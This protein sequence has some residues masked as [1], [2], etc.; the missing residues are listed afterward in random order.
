MSSMLSVEAPECTQCGDCA[1]ACPMGLITVDDDVPQTAPEAP[2]RCMLCGHCVAACPTSA[3]SH[4][5][6]RPE[7]CASI[8]PGLSLN[9][10]QADQFLRGRRSIRVYRTD[11][12]DR[13]A[14]ARLIGTASTGPSGHNTQPVEWLVIHDTAEVR[15][16]TGFVIDW[17]RYM[18][19]QQPDFAK[20]I[21]L[22][23]VVETWEKGHDAVCRNAP[24]V[25]LTYAHKDNGMAPSACTIALAY[26]ELAAQAN[27]L[28]ACW[29]GY[30]D[31]A[32]R[33]WSPLQKE[34]GLPAD[35]VSYG[36]MMIG[37]PKFKYHRIPLRKDARIS[38]K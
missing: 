10:D 28:G 1:T 8:K 35:N 19:E 15:R 16:L 25:V 38:W 3:L 37:Y 2:S 9:A 5:A 34:L 27:G 21:L 33:Y 24:H 17:M 26:L 22:D 36:A 30:F 14:L 20:M 4:R 23:H 29:A 7:Q 12:V 11:P 13:A 6:M 32:A 18:L 31:M